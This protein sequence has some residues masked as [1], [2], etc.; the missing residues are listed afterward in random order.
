LNP[1]A[2]LRSWKANSSETS[3]STNPLKGGEGETRLRNGPSLIA[4]AAAGRRKGKRCPNCGHVMIES[5]D[6]GL[7]C[8]NCSYHC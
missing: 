4:E 6:G 7:G 2:T 3:R 8:G 5:A 1:R